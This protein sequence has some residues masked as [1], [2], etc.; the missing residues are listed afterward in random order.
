VDPTTKKHGTQRTAQTW[1]RCS[2]ANL[3]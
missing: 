3:T 1:P 2:E